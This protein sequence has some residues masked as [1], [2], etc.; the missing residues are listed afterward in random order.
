MDSVGGLAKILM[1]QFRDS[2]LVPRV[3]K[4]S[5]KNPFLT[6]AAP[7][8]PK[9]PKSPKLTKTNKP[10]NLLKHY[11]LLKLPK[12]Y[13]PSKLPKIYK[14]SKF[15]KLCKTAVDKAG[16]LAKESLRPPAYRFPDSLSGGRP[17]TYKNRNNCIYSEGPFPDVRAQNRIEHP[18]LWSSF[19]VVTVKLAEC[20][21]LSVTPGHACSPGL[22]PRRQESTK[23]G[24]LI[25]GFPLGQ[26]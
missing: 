12:A 26:E 6:G 21:G 25:S 23:Q 2:Y 11:E 13:K 9:P 3:F 19:P 22:F 5:P 8:L 7:K 14:L 17:E 15:P 16:G 10:L 4:G 1:G 18:R 20:K 24:F